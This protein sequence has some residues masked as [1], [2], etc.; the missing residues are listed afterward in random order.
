LRRTFDRLRGKTKTGDFE[1]LLKKA[2]Q[3][4]AGEK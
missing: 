3:E 4:R 1:R 2:H